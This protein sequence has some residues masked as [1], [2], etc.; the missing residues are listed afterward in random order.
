[1][2]TVITGT[3]GFIASNLK[4]KFG[5][6]LL[7]DVIE[8]NSISPATLVSLLRDQSGDI[9]VVYHLGA[10]SSTTET[11][12]AKIAEHNIKFSCNLLE[13]CIEKNIPFVYAS[14]ASVYGLG[15]LGFSESS[16]LNPLNYYAI[17]KTAFDMFVN[18]KILD[19]P[20][21]KIVGLRYFNVYGHNEDHK[22]DMASPIHKFLKQ[23]TVGK[24]KVF[25]GS[26]DFRRDFIHVDDVV[27]I[28]KAAVKF[29]SGI[30]NVGTGLPRTF[31][32]VATIIS[33]ITGAEIKEIPF[34][35]HLI[36]KYQNFTCSD[37]KEINHFYKKERIS[38]EDGIRMVYEN[39]LR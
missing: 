31:L 14:S 34:P 4:E 32:D 30:Y 26:K 2:T 12:V 17:S 19:N 10:I 15:K 8:D 39:R 11:N 5:S 23:A 27:D 28:T 36:G 3:A 1:M 38:L 33:K 22:N 18:Q 24:I 29:K 7:C 9:D 13:S 25:E 35:D 20:E 37:N 6:T 21:A 16:R